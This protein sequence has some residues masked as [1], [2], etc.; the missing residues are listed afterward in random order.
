[1][2]APTTAPAIWPAPPTS[3]I[4]KSSMPGRMSNGVGFT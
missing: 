1:M 4:S 3:A 2:A